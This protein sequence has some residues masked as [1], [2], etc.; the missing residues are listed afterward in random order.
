VVGCLLMRSCAGKQGSKD[1]KQR[2][3]PFEQLKGRWG[4]CRCSCQVRTAAKLPLLA[5]SSFHSI[6]GQPVNV[7]ARMCR[8]A[9]GAQLYRAHILYDWLMHA[10]W[11]MGARQVSAASGVV[12]L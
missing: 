7:R 2:S 8:G 3:I 9:G 5:W 1:C 6:R 12:P 4:L 10:S 11:L